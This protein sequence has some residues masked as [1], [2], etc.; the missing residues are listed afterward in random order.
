M[1]KIRL[2][3]I[4]GMLGGMLIAAAIPPAVVWGWGHAYASAASPAAVHS[5]K[6]MA[7]RLAGAMNNRSETVAFT[8]EGRTANLKTQ[9]QAALDQAMESD[10]YLH[11]VIGS[12]GFSYRGSTRSAK[13]TV[14]IKYL[15][16]LQQTAYVT[17]EVKA[18]LK[19][20]ITPGMNNHEK[21]KAIHDWV[22]LQLKY[23]TSYRKYTAFEGLQSGSAVCQGYSLLTYRML[24][25]A[26]I[27]NKIVEGTARPEGGSS[28][29]HAWNLVQLDGRWYHL[30]TTWD[31]PSPD[32][33]GVISTGYYLR[34]DKQMREDHSWTKTYP[35]ASV[36]YY[37][38]LRELAG[39]G[40]VKT[41]FYQKLQEQLDYGLYEEARIISSASGIMN[42][43][44]KAADSGEMEM[45]FRYR[46]SRAELESDLQRLYGLGLDNLAYKCSA[47][48]NTGDLKVFVSWE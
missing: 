28:Q 9:V 14:Q 40:G 25:E 32:Q 33:A 37:Q 5:I 7:A 19:E 8:Y 44:G 12:Y 36:P 46:G 42:L 10:P 24:K 6:E 18:A 39:T 31:D 17:R 23:D 43:A 22:V 26:G 11:Y 15:E 35:A 21:V 3:L 2:T 13:V 34:T 30:D 4:K 27:N 41:A 47:F 38:T 1:R 29:S 20:I 16:T 45:L 48:E